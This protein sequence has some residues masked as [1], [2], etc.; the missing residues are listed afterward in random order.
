M[1][2][3]K[4]VLAVSAICLATSSI[5]GG[6]ANAEE[7]VVNVYNWSDY[8]DESVLEDFTKE[9]GIK[10]NYDVF[11]TNELLETKLLAGSSGYDVVVPSATFISRQIK[12]GAF[13][14]LDKSKL[15][16]LKNTWDKIAERTEKYDPDNAHSFNYMWGTTGVGYVAEK[17]KERLGDDVPL[18]SWDLIFKPEIVE[19]LADCGIHWLD[20]PM[21]MVPAALHYLGLDPGDFSK[22]NLKKAEELI[23]KVRPHVQ[24]FHS[25]EYI[26]ALANGD[27]CLAVGY[28]GD[29]LQ[30]RDRAKEAKNGNTVA[31]VIPK[32]GA[33]MWFDQMA[34]P[35]DAKN[36]DEAYAFLDFVLRPDVAAKASNYVSFANGNLASQKLLDDAVFK[37]NAVYP[38][39][40]TLKGLYVVTL[41]EAKAQRVLNR[42]WTRIK[43]GK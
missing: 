23:A 26:G 11:D 36:V 1:V 7:R 15:P 20:A 41:P 33:Q 3:S 39:E 24:K 19:K 14:K 16:N 35:A 17:V 5:L 2:K 9:T 30:A 28:S 6:V 25:S 21:E 42:T 10:V 43:S 13:A 29:V 4:L 27:I 37:D 40:E 32:E 22:E 18:N 31:Y 8:I 34:I 38:D 12:A